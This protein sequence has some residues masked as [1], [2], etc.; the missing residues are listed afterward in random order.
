MAESNIG[1]ILVASPEGYPLGIITDTDLR[2]KVVA[3]PGAVNER[4]VNEI[5]SSPVYTITGGKTVAD[6][7]ML[8]VKTKLRHFCITEDGTPRSPIL[9]I[10]SEHDI[11]TFRRQ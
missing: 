4:P 2:K 10:I 5:M 9:G 1:S 6:M 3:L 11:I 7:V 8:M